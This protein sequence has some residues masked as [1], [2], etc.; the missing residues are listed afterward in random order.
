M[1]DEMFDE[2]LGSV[3]E[4]G[5]ILRGE[6]APARTFPLESPDVRLIREQVGLPQSRFASLLGVS[7]ETVRSW[8]QGRRHPSGPARVLLSLLEKNPDRVLGM[9]DLPEQVG[10]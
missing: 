1:D 8:E 7:A 5:R 2:L 6:Q 10:A 4:A 9:L 3:R